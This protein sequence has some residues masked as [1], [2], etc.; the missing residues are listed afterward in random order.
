VDKEYIYNLQKNAKTRHIIVGGVLVVVI[1]FFTIFS[2][3]GL[4]KRLDLELDRSEMINKIEN[5]IELRDSLKNLKKVLLK[6]TF[7]IERLA[8]EKYGYIREGEEIYFIDGEE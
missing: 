2:D 3:H 4:Y 5:E 6:D 1:S 8:R 7:E